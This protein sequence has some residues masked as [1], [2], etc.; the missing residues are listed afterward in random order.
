LEEVDGAR[1]DNETNHNKMCGDE[2][3]DGRWP[4]RHLRLRDDDRLG[5]GDPHDVWMGHRMLACVAVQIRQQHST[6]Y[7]K[8]RGFQCVLHGA[9]E[10]CRFG[11]QSPTRTLAKENNEC[12]LFKFNGTCST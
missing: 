9:A 11:R 7:D 8:K 4:H 3:R 10:E 6:D 2:D 5:Q 12:N 1:S